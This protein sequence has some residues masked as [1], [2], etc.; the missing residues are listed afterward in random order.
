MRVALPHNLGREEV[1]RRLASR[2]HE[3]GDMIPGG[4]A[5]V[6][7]DWP[8]ENIM[9]LTVD[10]M[11]QKITG[12]IEIHDAQVIIEFELPGALTFF[13][14]MIE[15]AVRSNTARLLEKK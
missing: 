15:S 2:S 5:R 10:A 9:E 7:S 1:R 3:I 6:R 8:S 4:M 13:Q 12:D 11:G 14:P